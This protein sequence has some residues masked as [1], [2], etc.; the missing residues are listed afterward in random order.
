VHTFFDADAGLT[1]GRAGSSNSPT[2]VPIRSGSWTGSSCRLT[3]APCGSV[4]SV[5]RRPRSR[6]QPYRR[7]ESLIVVRSGSDLLG[8]EGYAEFLYRSALKCS[9]VSATLII[10]ARSNATARCRPWAA[11]ESSSASSRTG[12]LLVLADRSVP[13]VRPRLSVQLGLLH[14]T[15]R[16]WLSLQLHRAVPVS[17]VKPV[18]LMRPVAR[19]GPTGAIPPCGPVAPVGPAMPVTPVRP[20]GRCSR[21]TRTHWTG[22]SRWPERADASLRSGC[23]GW[24]DRSRR[25]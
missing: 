4:V 24:A 20:T 11:N 6:A 7:F 19:V 25:S 12:V 23:T 9:S 15:A 5:M 14:R 17:P 18:A 21:H 1:D 10:A 2:G 8:P 3:R 22:R 13:Q 16:V